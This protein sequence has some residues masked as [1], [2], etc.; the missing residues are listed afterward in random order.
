MLPRPD[1]ILTHESDLDGLISGVLLKRLARKLFNIVDLERQMR[2]I[3][4][5]LHRPASGK[6]AKLDEFFAARR[7][8]ENQFRSA[9]RLVSIDFLKPENLAIKFHRAFQIIHTVTRMQQFRDNAHGERIAR[10]FGRVQ[11]ANPLC[12]RPGLLGAT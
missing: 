10:L 7:F 3:G 6:T 9:R 1:V 2:E 4:L 11:A 5:H 8:Q 12:S